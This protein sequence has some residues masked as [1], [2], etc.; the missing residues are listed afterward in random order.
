MAVSP[1]EQSHD[2]NVADKTKIQC[3]GG[4]IDATTWLRCPDSYVDD[5]C[6]FFNYFTNFTNFLEFV[7]LVLSIL[8]QK[9]S[10]IHFNFAL[11]MH[12]CSDRSH[13]TC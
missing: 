1:P 5:P 11:Y 7:E 10:V 9:K 12:I 3:N 2:H 8:E 13:I 6:P 4:N